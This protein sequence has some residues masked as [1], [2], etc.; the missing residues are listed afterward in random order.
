MADF[1]CAVVEN[2]NGTLGTAVPFLLQK[3]MSSLSETAIWV[4]CNWLSK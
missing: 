2:M 1:M 3:H 4:V